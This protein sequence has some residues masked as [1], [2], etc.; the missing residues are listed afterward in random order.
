VGK[1]R[2]RE[3]GEHDQALGEGIGEKP[4]RSGELMVISSWGGGSERWG[5]PLESTR[6]PEGRRLSGLNGGDLSQNAQH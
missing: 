2:R 3:K 5:N 6:D 4:R 1:G